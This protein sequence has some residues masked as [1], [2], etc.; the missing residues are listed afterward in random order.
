MTIVPYSLQR[1]HPPVETLAQI[2]CKPVGVDVE[3]SPLRSMAMKYLWLMISLSAIL[4]RLRRMSSRFVTN[5][6]RS[7]RIP[8]SIS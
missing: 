6:T 4:G 5:V 3:R 7:A 1:G 2:T 8:L